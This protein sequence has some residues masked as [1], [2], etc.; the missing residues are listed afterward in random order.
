MCPIVGRP[1][2][3][4]SRNNIDIWSYLRAVYLKWQ[5]IDR[6]AKRIRYLVSDSCESQ[7]DIGCYGSDW[8]GS[9]VVDKVSSWAL[10]HCS[11]MQNAHEPMRSTSWTGSVSTYI[12]VIWSMTIF[13]TIGIGVLRMRSEVVSSSS[14]TLM[15]FKAFDSRLPIFITVDTLSYGLHRDFTGGL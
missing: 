12:L 10:D 15:S 2:R 3:C 13:Y 14:K 7:D 1:R 8:D 6:I 4:S 11:H 5:V 9:S